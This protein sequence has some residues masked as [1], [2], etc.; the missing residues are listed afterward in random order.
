MYQPIVKAKTIESLGKMV[1]DLAANTGKFDEM[2]QAFMTI[3]TKIRDNVLV[4]ER[5]I[6]EE[7]RKVIVLLE[8]AL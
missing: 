3:R 6:A 4:E 5:Q 8:V 7:T 2:V 1:K